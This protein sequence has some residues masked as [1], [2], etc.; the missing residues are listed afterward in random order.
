MDYALTKTRHTYLE[1][2][3][4]LELDVLALIPQQVHHHL[5]IGFA[6]DVSRHDIE[7]CA[8]EQNLAQEFQRLTFRHIV[9]RKN[10]CGK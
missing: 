7:V 3:E 1:H 2:V 10:E 9:V 8:V 5:Q 4:R 6:G